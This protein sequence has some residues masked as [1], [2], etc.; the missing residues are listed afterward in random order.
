MQTKACVALSSG[1]RWCCTGTP[2]STS[3]EDLL[4]QFAAVHLAPMSSKPYFDTHL[5]HVFSH[6]QAARYIGL[7]TSGYET[8]LYTLRG[9]LV[10]HVKTQVLAGEQ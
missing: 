8:L 4:G 9:V 1:R 3:V 2:V 6:S 7:Q 5:K 10:R